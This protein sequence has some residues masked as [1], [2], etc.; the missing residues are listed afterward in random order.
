MQGEEK[1]KANSNNNKQQ[2][3]KKY[4]TQTNSQPGVYNYT[5]KRIGMI[6]QLLQFLIIQVWQHWFSWVKWTLVMYC[7]STAIYGYQNT[8]FDQ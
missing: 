6:E 2:W 1:Y 8:K 7:D 5:L 4:F 3:E